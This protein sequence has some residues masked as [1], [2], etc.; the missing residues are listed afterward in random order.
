MKSTVAMNAPLCSNNVTAHDSPS[1]RLVP[2]AL[3][4]NCHTPDKTPAVSRLALPFAACQSVRFG[5]RPEP[6]RAG[7]AQHAAHAKHRE[8]PAPAGR[9]GLLATI[10]VE[11]DP[12]DR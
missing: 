12:E 10:E 6:E 4:S 7:Q 3:T 5:Q 11:H 8:R 9:A 2:S 1:T